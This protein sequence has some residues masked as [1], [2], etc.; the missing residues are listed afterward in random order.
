MPEYLKEPG[1]Q[2]RNEERLKTEAF[3]LALA[4]E[5]YGLRCE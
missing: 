3:G 5:C 4:F 1:Q 2:C